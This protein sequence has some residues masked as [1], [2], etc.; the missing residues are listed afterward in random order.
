MKITNDYLKLC[1]FKCDVEMN[2]SAHF[3]KDDSFEIIDYSSMNLGRDTTW[4]L[5]I[6]GTKARNYGD[7]RLIANTDD[8]DK[9]K[10]FLNAY[11]INPDKYF[12]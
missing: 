6:F 9:M 8:L 4:E 2:L 1:G 5:I 12:K 3:W 7:V 11:D 10:L